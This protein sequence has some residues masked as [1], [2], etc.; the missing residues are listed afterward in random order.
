MKLSRT[1][2]STLS[3]MCDAGSITVDHVRICWKYDYDEIKK[4]IWP[5]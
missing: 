5:T 2:Y 1:E 4:N 3:K